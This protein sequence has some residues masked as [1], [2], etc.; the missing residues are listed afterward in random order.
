MLL[1]APA[2]CSSLHRCAHRLRQRP[3]ICDEVSVPSLLDAS[4]RSP[5][6]FKSI[7]WQGCGGGLQTRYLEPPV[8]KLA[9]SKGR[10]VEIA[11]VLQCGPCRSA[12]SQQYGGLAGADSQ[13][14]AGVSGVVPRAAAGLDSSRSPWRNNREASL[15]QKAGGRRANPCSRTCITRSATE[16]NAKRFSNRRTVRGQQFAA[17][18]APCMAAE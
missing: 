3:S 16:P 4:C 15:L 9:P 11:R 13:S 8:P 18:T 6:S 1:R 12:G 10:H 2:S 14:Q 5:H 17:G 7:P